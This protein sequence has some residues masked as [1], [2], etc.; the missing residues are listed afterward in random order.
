M[1]TRTI[2]TVLAVLI[3]TT[4]AAGGLP[5]NP[6]Y[7][8]SSTATATASATA[9]DDDLD[10]RVEISGTITLIKQQS[11]SVWIIVLD[12]GTEVL[13]NPASQGADGLKVGQTITIIASVDD[14]LFVAKIVTTMT[15]DAESTA[16]ATIAATI[17]AT[18]PATVVATVPA[19]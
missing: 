8:Q 3:L 11:V 13:V 19:N 6:T 2:L 10:P 5:N 7:A 12:D 9:T 18:V 16:A 4:L 1:S 15:A 17:P 14:E